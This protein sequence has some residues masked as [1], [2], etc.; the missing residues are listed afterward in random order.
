MMAI[1]YTLRILPVLVLLIV[2]ESCVKDDS[3]V[4][5]LSESYYAGGKTTIFEPTAFYFASHATILSTDNFS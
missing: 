5:E 4:N 1:K 3:K 2:I